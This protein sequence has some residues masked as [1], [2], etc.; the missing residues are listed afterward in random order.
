M[1]LI[2]ILTLILCSIPTT[3]WAQQLSVSGEI[4]QASADGVAPVDAR[5]LPADVTQ[6]S[7]ASEAEATASDGAL[8]LDVG[9]V[10]EIRVFDTP[11]LSGKFQVDSHGNITLPVGGTVEVKGLTPEQLQISV[12]KRFRQREILRD[13]HVEVFVLEYV[14]Q[15]V[16]VMGEVKNPGV[17]PIGGK[18]S[19]LDFISIAGGPTSAASKTALLTH[20]A[21]PAQVVTVDLGVSAQ[22]SRKHRPSVATAS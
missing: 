5:A 17:Y 2:W 4:P 19:I 8:L 15:R 12:E 11:E 18:R 3:I 10:L 7:H 14:T 9:D 16:T 13:P 22:T 1:K 20:K 6:S 21:S